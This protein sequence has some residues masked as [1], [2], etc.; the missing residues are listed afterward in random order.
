MRIMTIALLSLTLS[1]CSFVKLTPAGDNVAI[2][3]AGEVANCTPNGTTTVAV[4]D[5]VV[6]NR[7]PEKIVE[8]LRILARNRAAQD[9]RGDAIV[10]A[11]PIQD[12][13]QTFNIYKC[14]R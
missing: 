3:Q 5:K 4:I 10:P 8:E 7:S 13:E 12:G 1:A 14:R 6:V 2:L 9:N 11:G